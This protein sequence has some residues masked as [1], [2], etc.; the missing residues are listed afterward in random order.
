MFIVLGRFK[1]VTIYPQ[2]SCGGSE[3]D[4]FV[5]VNK[6]MILGDCLGIARCELENILFP[7]GMEIFGASK[8]GI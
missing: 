3:R 6:R 7:I 2:G 5:A 4:T 1:L 8:F